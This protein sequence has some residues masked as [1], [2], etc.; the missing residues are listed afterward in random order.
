M[1]LSREAYRALEDIVG[2]ENISEEPAVLDGYCFIW[3]NEV[4]FGDKFSARPPAVVMPG[5]TEEVQG[6]VKVC[7]R[8]NIKYRAHASGWEVPAISAKEPFLPVDLRRMNHILQM[9]NISVSP[10]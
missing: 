8:F 9:L 4:H 2:R 3:A 10:S 6:I 5:N 7:N 1:S